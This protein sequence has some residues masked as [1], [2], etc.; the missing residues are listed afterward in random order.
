MAMTLAELRLERG[1]TQRKLA[2]DLGLSESAI[3]MYEIGKRVPSLARA[4]EI[5]KY[6]GVAVED[7]FFG[8]G[9]HGMRAMKTNKHKAPAPAEAV[10]Q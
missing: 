10:N 6:F 7:I 4:K 1:I 2:K 5:A 9:A 8:P 3:A